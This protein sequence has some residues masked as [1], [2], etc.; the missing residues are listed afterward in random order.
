VKKIKINNANEENPN[1]DA[2]TQVPLSSNKTDNLRSR[3]Y[4]TI[5]R[6]TYT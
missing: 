1:M 5:V 2:A 3:N 4:S 6:S